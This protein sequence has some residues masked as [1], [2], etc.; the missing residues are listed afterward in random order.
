VNG[1]LAA[2]LARLGG[3]GVQ[4][5]LLE[6]GATLAGA[7]FRAEVV[8]KLLLFVAPT[9]SGEGP[10]L[11]TA[12]HEPV[13]LTRLSSRRIGQDLLLTAYVHEP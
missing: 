2:E 5:L 12:L 10:G 3:E 4:S 9:L 11:V 6:G 8:D 1:E 7:F 13:S